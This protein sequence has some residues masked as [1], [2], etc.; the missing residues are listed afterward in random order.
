MSARIEHPALSVRDALDTA[1]SLGACVTPDPETT[2]YV[3]RFPGL[4]GKEG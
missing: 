3:Q 1:Q 2:P 4:S